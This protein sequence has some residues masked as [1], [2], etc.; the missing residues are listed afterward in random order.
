MTECR[1]TASPANAA[2]ASSTM[3]LEGSEEASS[4]VCADFSC[5]SNGS[6]SGGI[7]VDAV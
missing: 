6:V 3:F 5:E 2:S 7:E 4:R 1:I